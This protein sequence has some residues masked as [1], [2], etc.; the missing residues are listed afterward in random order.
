[1]LIQTCNTQNKI[2]S[3]MGKKEIVHVKD[4]FIGAPCMSLERSPNA[5]V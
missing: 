3:L 5:P 4:T 1:M 2:K